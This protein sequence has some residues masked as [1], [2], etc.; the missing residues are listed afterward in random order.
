[1]TWRD[2]AASPIDFA[3]T[4]RLISVRI[5][6]ASYKG[7]WIVAETSELR[8]SCRMEGYCAIKSFVDLIVVY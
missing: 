3:S 7:R 4:F 6:N 1:M 5:G 2:V 8:I